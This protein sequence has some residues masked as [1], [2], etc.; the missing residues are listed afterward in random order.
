MSNNY[1]QFKQFT[2]FHDRCSMKVSTDGVLLGAWAEVDHIDL[3]LDIGTG[4]GLIALMIAQRSGALIDAVEIDPPAYQQA[5]ENVDRSPWKGRI[6]VYSGSFQLFVAVPPKKYDLIISNP[7]YFR[8]ALKSPD[9]GRSKAR[10]DISLTHEELLKGASLLLA[11][12]G[13]FCV[14]LPYSELENFAELASIYRLYC[15]R[16]TAAKANPGAVYSRVLMAF[17]PVPAGKPV[18]TE[19]TIRKADGLYSEDYRGLTKDFYL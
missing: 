2:V 11:P 4:S 12:Q 19:L 10:H 18:R 7:P 5:C 6:H 13:K 17:G 3:A 1:F 15:H 16:F 9:K 8:D 14:I